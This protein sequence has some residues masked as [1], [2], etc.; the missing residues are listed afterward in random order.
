MRAAPKAPGTFVCAS[1][2]GYY[3]DRGDDL[4]TEES[5]GGTGFLAELCRDWEAAARGAEVIG[6]R[7][8]N[9]RSGVIL[10]QGGGA[11]ANMLPAFRMGVAGPLGSG[12]QFFSWVALEDAVRA[13][14]FVLGNDAIRGPVNVTA[15]Q[16]VTNERFT[17]ALG[18]A[19]GRPTLLR[20]PAFA[21]RLA[22]GEMADEALLASQRAV[23]KKLEAAG[24][25]FGFPEVA[26]FLEREFAGGG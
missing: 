1:A 6:C 11:L 23:P 19:L 25:S 9:L 13:I 12:R 20:A 5:E 16:P 14:V 26:G 15:P 24:F 4:L 10:G 18:E 8:V 22:L 17:K 3:G 2:V 7:V 21:L